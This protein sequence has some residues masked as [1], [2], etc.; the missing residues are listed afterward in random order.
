LQVAD[1]SVFGGQAGNEHFFFL[2]PLVPS[3]DYSGTFDASL[4]PYLSIRVAGPF[5]NDLAATCE[6]PSWTFGQ[7]E[8]LSAGADQYSFGWKTGDYALQQDQ[9]YRLCVALAVPNADV[10]TLGFRDLSPASGGGSVAEDP[11]YRFNNG[12]NLAVKFRVEEGV[13]SDAFCSQDPTSD[14]NGYDCT[15]QILASN[16]SAYCDNFTCVLT[17][18]DVANDGSELF[19]VEKF[20]LGDAQ[21]TDGGVTDWLGVDIPQYAG[22]VRVTVPN[23]SFAGF[24]TQGIVGA[25]FYETSGPN[26]LKPEQDE[27][28]QLHVQYPGNIVWALPWEFAGIEGTCELAWPELAASQATSPVDRVVRLARRTMRKAQLALNPWF[29]PV[30]AYAF[31]TGFGGH[32]SLRSTDTTTSPTGITAGLRVDNGEPV[33][34]EQV[35]GLTANAEGDPQVF[36]LAWALPSQMNGTASSGAQS[37]GAGGTLLVSENTNVAVNV[38]VSDNGAAGDPRVAGTSRPVQGARVHFS[39]DGGAADTVPS[40][41]NGLAAFNW[42]AVGGGP[43]TISASGFGIGTAAT[44]GPFDSF[45]A[46]GAYSDQSVL[47]GTGTLTFNVFVCTN[48]APGFWSGDINNRAGATQYV[49]PV[50]LGGKTLDNSYLFVGNDCDSLYLALAVPVDEATNNSVRFVFD[51]TYP[52][53]GVGAG[54]ES[55]DDDILSVN[56]TSGGWLFRDRYLSTACLGSKQSDCGPNDQAGGGA[57]NGAG[58]AAWEGSLNLGATRTGYFVYRIRHPLASGDLGF[59]FQRSFGRTVGFYLAVSL[60]TGTKGNTEWP[61]QNTRFKTYQGYRIAGPTITP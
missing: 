8:G 48:S 47:L 38:Q 29:A 43:H 24:E 44:G 36:L 54:F 23:A 35:T 27:S 53:V 25:C 5:A 32:T 37:I 30:K 41:V 7:A 55:A 19:V 39:V 50:N 21:C 10:I 58:S 61:T 31:H 1:G 17:A 26:P 51:N 46:N 14:P 34:T 15:A 3:P 20:G 16:E 28:I 6:S 60:G 13:L 9:V 40:G 52:S 49:F 22:C 4:L 56:K 11:V 42:T 57:Q 59:D 2:P 33:A 45:D 18:G 12:S